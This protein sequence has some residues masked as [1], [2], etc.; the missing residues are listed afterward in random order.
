MTDETRKT[1]VDMSKTNFGKAVKDYLNEHKEKMGD[2]SKATLDDLK[3][4]QLTVSFIKDF[5]RVIEGGRPEE[6][7][8]NS[9]E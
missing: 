5:L 2:I 8:G 3:A 6:I 4:R 7:K 9:Y 1:L